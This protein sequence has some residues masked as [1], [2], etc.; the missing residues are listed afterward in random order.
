MVAR[1]RRRGLVSGN[2]S[3]PVPYLRRDGGADTTALTVAFTQAT[4]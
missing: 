4:G 3:V 2:T 1:L